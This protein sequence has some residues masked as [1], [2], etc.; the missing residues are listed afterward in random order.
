SLCPFS[1][2][3]LLPRPPPPS[4]LFP[5]TTL[6]RSGL[7]LSWP[8]S[9]PPRRNFVIKIVEKAP[10]ASV[11]FGHSSFDSEALGGRRRF[12]GHRR[13]PAQA[14]H[15]LAGGFDPQITGSSDRGA[16]FTG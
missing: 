13:D 14:H 1:S 7:N 16:L 15:G 10:I 6:F 11:R 8:T 2:L 3:V 4:T 9:G 12:G 5:Y